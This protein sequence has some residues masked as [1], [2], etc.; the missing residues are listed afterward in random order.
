V[1]VTGLRDSRAAELGREDELDRPAVQRL[2]TALSRLLDPATAAAL[3]TPADMT[4]TDS[5]PTGGAYLL[6]GLWRR[7]GIDTAIRDALVGKRVD[8]TR[9]ERIVF[10]LAAN[11]ALK[12]PP[13]PPRVG[14][15]SPVVRLVDDLA[16]AVDVH[17]VGDPVGRPAPT[18]AQRQQRAATTGRRPG[19]RRY[20]APLTRGTCPWQ[21]TRGFVKL[22]ASP[23][24]VD[25]AWYCESVYKSDAGARPGRYPG[26]PP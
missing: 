14:R 13:P 2:V 15:P 22:G 17:V 18:T 24:D 4:M 3:T 1:Q 11:H 23:A 5:R 10:A 19:R 6:D 20:A 12:P 9:V 21:G 16:Q 8:A 25:R 7:L 26:L